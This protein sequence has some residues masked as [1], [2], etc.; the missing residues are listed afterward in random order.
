MQK[1]SFP[2]LV[3]VASTRLILGSLPGD[4]SISFGQYYAH[5]QNRFWKILFQLWDLPY[6]NS[7]EER[8]LLLKKNH[9][10]LWDVCAEAIRSGS[11]DT[12]IMDEKPNAIHALLDE[13]PRIKSIYFNGQ[14]AQKLYDKHFTRLPAIT[15]HT[16][17]SSSPANASF[18]LDRLIAIWNTIR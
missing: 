10:A 15:Y 5:P 14:K 13:Y 3:D 16:L 11:M 4:M 18:T 7:Y 12:A 2:P 8:T 1:V 6:S 9:V 17:P